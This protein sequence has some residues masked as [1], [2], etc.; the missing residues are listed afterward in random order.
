M[1]L[2]EQL[3]IAMT[4]KLSLNQLG[5]VMIWFI[6]VTECIL[7]VF[8]YIYLLDHMCKFNK[9]KY[10]YK[11]E[12]AIRLWWLK[13]SLDELDFSSSSSCLCCDY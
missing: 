2:L 12:I 5:Y 4:S 7:F 9:S 3:L 10:N 6:D 1:Q 11:K 8:I 13:L